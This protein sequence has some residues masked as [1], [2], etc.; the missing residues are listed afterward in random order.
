MK[1]L[2]AYY[3]HSGNNEKVA[4]ELKNRIGCP[5]YQIL[6][7]KRRKT[8][9]ILWDILFKRN[10]KLTSSS[11]DLKE[12]DNVILVAPIWSG[13]VST[14]MRAFIEKERDN[15]N[16][17]YYVTVCNGEVGQKEKLSSE[18]SALA[19]RSPRSVTELSINN[20][21]PEEQRHKVKYTFNY[22]ISAQDI[23]KF[24]KI[25]ESLTSTLN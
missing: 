16:N 1:T 14:P 5:I 11:V 20:L 3:S 4:H 10:S 8:I 7:K 25:L 12:Y 15:L 21:L 13:R 18:L 19:N 6:E 24:D 23:Q 2:I 22:R 17:Y 9:S